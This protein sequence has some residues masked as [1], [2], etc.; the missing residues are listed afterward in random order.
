M[1]TYSFHCSSCE[2]SF[3]KILRM[4][5]RKNP[6]SEPC[7]ECGNLNVKNIIGSPKIVSSVGSI[8]SKTDNG[9]NDVLKRI[10]S[11][12]GRKNT[13]HVK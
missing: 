5:D 8:L 12:S 13:V 4:D 7:P 2:Y 6:E 11:G 1:P 3:D 9:W 10:K